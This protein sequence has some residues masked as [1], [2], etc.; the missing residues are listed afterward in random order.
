M[1]RFKE[2]LE[3]KYTPKLQHHKDCIEQGLLRASPFESHRRKSSFVTF[4][5]SEAGHFPNHIVDDVALGEH[6]V[7]SKR[8]DFNKYKDSKVLVIGGGPSTNELDFG[9]T[10]ADFLW[11]CNHFYLN[12]VLK[13][14]KVDMAMIMG[15]PDIK[16]KEFL[17]YRNKFEPM[18]GFEIH[19]RWKGY[20]FDDYKKYFLMHTDFYSKLGAGVRMIIFACALGVKEVYFV[21]LDGTSYIKKGEHAFEKGKTTLPSFYNE[22][23]YKYQYKLF[24]TY[25]S[26][27]FPDVS[28]INLGYGQENH[29]Q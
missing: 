28:F 17:E 16:S 7:F 18:I 29:I 2:N 12:P 21:G 14:T 3:G 9:S 20:P 6:I 10:G 23:S 5:K 11:S 25:V 24:W 1:S 19:N 4:V 8:S 15:E 13:N 27:C 26:S 22:E